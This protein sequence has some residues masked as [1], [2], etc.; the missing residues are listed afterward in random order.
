MHLF[1]A[2]VR[3]TEVSIDL[4]GIA[5]LIPLGVGA[6]VFVGMDLVWQDPLAEMAGGGG[7]EESV[8]HG[9]SDSSGPILGT[10]F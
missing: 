8:W 7:R 4:V 1:G 2:P 3:S 6:D 9:L 10:T 5:E